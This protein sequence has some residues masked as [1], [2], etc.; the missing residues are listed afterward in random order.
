MP[1]K[2]RFAVVSSKVV[3]KGKRFVAEPWS[4]KKGVL[5][6]QSVHLMP[7]DNEGMGVALCLC[8]GRNLNALGLGLL[9]GISY[10]F[11]L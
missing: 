7:G 2:Y 4:T 8:L 10:A 5:N 9:L 6:A 3:E 1:F 11:Q